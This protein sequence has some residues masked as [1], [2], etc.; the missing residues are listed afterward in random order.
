M[1]KRKILRM[2]MRDGTVTEMPVFAD[3]DAVMKAV[4]S[5]PK[6]AYLV[7]QVWERGRWV[8]MPNRRPYK[9]I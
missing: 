1:K 2:Y 5:D 4:F 3:D 9:I 8:N 6:A 7:K